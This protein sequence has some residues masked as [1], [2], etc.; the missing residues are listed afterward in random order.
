MKYKNYLK[1][2]NLSKNTI[3]A[4]LRIYDNW[5]KYLNDK[6]PNKTLVVNY[7]KKFSKNHKPS[8]IH[9]EFSGILSILIFQKQNK[10]V[11]ECKNIRLPK[12]ERTLKATISI[13]EFNYLKQF[14]NLDWYSYRDFLIFSFLF[15]TGIRVSE[16]CNIK[17]NK[18]I[19]NSIEIIGKGAKLRT[20]YINNYLLSLLKQ[21]NYNYIPISRNK[22]ILT[23]KQINLIIKKIGIKY[24]N[25]NITP[26]SLR[27]SYATHL[28][29]KGINIEIIRKILGHANINTTSRYIQYTEDEIKEEI[30]KVLD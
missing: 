7:I 18:I 21:W 3:I 30:F 20:I 14:N 13:N 17:I 28:I 6:K 23:I 29:K 15:F 8:S 19:N 2:K 16:L 5:N 9:L 1:N 24:F 27:R 12:E 11:N 4:Y 25:K 10:L 26:H 22:K